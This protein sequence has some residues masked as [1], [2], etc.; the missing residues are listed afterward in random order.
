MFLILALCLGISIILQKVLSA[1]EHITTVF[2]FG[3]FLVSLI[4]D[5]YIYGLAFS[6]I[7]VFAVNY[8]FAFPY[9]AFN[10]TIPE[11][12]LSAL[13]MIVISFM[14]ST[15]TTKLKKWQE[16]KAAEEKEKMRANLLRAVSHDIRTPL[17]TIYGASSTVLESYST[18]SDEQKLKMINDIKGDSEW[19]T[20]LVENLLSITKFNG[21]NINLIKTPT[22]LEE[23]VDSAMLK[24]N[25]RH[26]S[27]KINIDIPNEMVVFSVD[28][29]LIEQVI[30][31]I[32]ENAIQHAKGMTMLELRVYCEKNKAIF[33]IKDN[34]CGIE[35]D[36]LKYIF[37]E[38]YSCEDQPSDTHKRASGLGLSICA[39]IIKAHGGEIRAENVET[40]GA[41]FIFS[42]KMEDIIDDEYQQI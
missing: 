30:G 38:Y 1:D 4:T 11:N 37:T 41:K 29:I 28:A 22:V 14:T 7:G 6:L 21:N 35:P 42:L 2:V 10:F 32:L 17:T 25:N 5:G 8:A 31:N 39:T 23:L 34:G 33:E 16:F 9:F 27:Q 12:F 15:L 18:L 3:A 13:I 20:R 40:G 19:L 36:R 26:P 24:F